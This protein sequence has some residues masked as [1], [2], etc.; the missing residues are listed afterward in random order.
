MPK[1]ILAVWYSQTGQLSEIIHSFTQPL[2]EAGHI[3]EHFTI[4]PKNP[5][6]FP[7]TK[8][9]FL[10]VMP[11]CVFQKTVL[12]E[13]LELKYNEYDL[14]IIGFQPWYLHLS[15]PSNSL[16]NDEKIKKIIHQKPVITISDAR[17]MWVNAL[18]MAKNHLQKANAYHIGHISRVDR[19]GNLI[20]LI[21]IMNWMKKGFKERHLKIFPIPG[22]NQK[23]IKEMSDFGKML[24]P[25][26]ENC[27]YSNYQKELIAAKGFELKNNL[28]FMEEKAVKLFGLWARFIN[29]RKNKKF[30]LRVYD[31][32]LT[33][34]LFIF[35]P[36]VY[37]VNLALFQPFNQRNI[38]QKLDTIKKL[39]QEKDR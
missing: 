21:T 12:L 10:S 35:A 3:V 5:Y 16:F 7:W 27:D 32:Y 26:L 29:N 9:E 31:T 28:V 1:K 6:P 14:I 17:N 36:I 33:V 25:K 4:K 18:K 23:D 22:V 15:L 24:L 13:D 19:H 34:A 8:D 11:D 20:S 2:I 39:N 37:L 38:N 30:W